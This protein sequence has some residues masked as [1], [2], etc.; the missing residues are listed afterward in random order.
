[1]ILNNYNNIIEGLQNKFNKKFDYYLE[2]EFLYIRCLGIDS[3]SLAKYIRD[4][5]EVERVY[6]KKSDCRFM[7]DSNY[8]KITKGNTK[9]LQI[10]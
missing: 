10:I 7:V 6:V 3:L 9:I 8:I 5:Y 2:D 4:L 1:M